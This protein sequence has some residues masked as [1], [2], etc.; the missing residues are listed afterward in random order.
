M[1]TAHACVAM[2]LK[3]RRLG[4][5]KVKRMGMNLLNQG[6]EGNATIFSGE[7]GNV[8]LMVIY[9]YY[10]AFDRIGC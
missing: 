6:S 7:W 3:L 1:I 8:L 2:W 4:A 5:Y 9:T 10:S